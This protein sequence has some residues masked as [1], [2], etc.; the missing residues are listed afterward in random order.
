MEP[1]KPRNV[2]LTTEEKEQIISIIADGM[3]INTH[4]QLFAW[5]QGPVQQFLPHD[6]MISAWGDFSNWNLKLDVISAV[7]GARTEWISRCDGFGRCSL[8]GALRTFFLRWSTN[9][10]RPFIVPVKGLLS[11]RACACPLTEAVQV[12]HSI[13]V[14]GVHDERDAYDSL[15]MTL[16][17]RSMRYSDQRVAYVASFLIPQIDIAFRKVAS[18]PN[19]EITALKRPNGESLGLTLREKEIV[20]WICRGKINK[21]IGAKLNISTFTVKNHLRRIFRKLGA[22]NRT[23]VVMK[24]QQA[25]REGGLRAG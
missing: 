16:L 17:P 3:P 13:L 15:Y 21:E 8:N 5:L 6:I 10:R 2:V 9:E 22:S 23:D 12:M 7:P 11:P 20:D 14:H 25:R 19:A 24:Y 1:A 18:L 4:S